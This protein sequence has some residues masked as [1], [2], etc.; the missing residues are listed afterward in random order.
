MRSRHAAASEATGDSADPPCGAA[1]SEMCPACAP[2]RARRVRP[3]CAA[4]RRPRR[5]PRQGGRVALLPPV[6]ERGRP[7]L[8]SA[9]RAREARLTGER[10]AS[11]GREDIEEFCLPCVIC[12]KDHALASVARRPADLLAEARVLA[13]ARHE[14]APH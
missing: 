9:V 4:V 8:V 13:R 5:R 3:P 1:A 11:G 2:P 10:G 12:E 7:V 6:P 14:T